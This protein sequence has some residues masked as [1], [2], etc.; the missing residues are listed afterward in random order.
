MQSIWSDSKYSAS[1]Y[2]TKIL[3]NTLGMRELFSYPKSP[4]TVSD[5]ILAISNEDKGIILDY[6]A[7]SGTTAHAVINLNR[8]DGGKRKYILVEQGEYFDTVLKPRVQKVI[9]SEHWKDGK[10]VAGEQGCNGV[11]QIVK[12]LKLESYEDT[13]NNL[14][15]QPPADLLT[16][17]P[18]VQQDY[19]LHY[20]LDSESRA[21]LLNTDDFRQ[22][23]GYRLNIAAD[24][25]G[26]AVPMVMDLVETF[27]YLLGLRVTAVDDQRHHRGYVFVEGHMPGQSAD[28]KTLVVWRDCTRWD[29]DRLPELL[30]KRDVNP[31][32]QEYAQVYINGDHNIA[33][34][35]AEAFSGSLKLKPTEPEFLRLM[36]DEGVQ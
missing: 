10:P 7:G 16:L 8:E 20:M 2:G 29:Y 32:S 34:V 6:F 31:A 36:F 3:D 1:D 21:S 5:A 9:Y 12:V 4:H 25:A 26:A 23:F 22:P 18:G 33:T 24:S 27:N 35:W 19:R 30:A 28:E 15:L 13:L 14:A 11:A 17:P